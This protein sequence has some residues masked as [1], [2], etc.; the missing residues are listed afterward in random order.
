MIPGAGLFLPQTSHRSKVQ[1]LSQA[2]N[3]R[4]SSIQHL[5]DEQRMSQDAPSQESMKQKSDSSEDNTSTSD[6][7][8]TVFDY[9]DFVFASSKRPAEAELFASLIWHTRQD[10]TEASRLYLSPIVSSFLEAWPDRKSWI[11]KTVLDI[12]TAVLDIG[13]HIESVRGTRDDDEILRRRHKFRYTLSHQ[14]HLAQKQRTLANT[15]QVLLA[16]IQVMQTVEQC[17]GLGHGSRDPIFEA[18][19]R[20]WLRSDSELIRAPYSRRSSARNLSA[21]SVTTSEVADNHKS[22]SSFTK[23]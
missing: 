14:K 13:M 12:R 3:G 9:A 10:L 15:H 2:M 16:A 5:R 17:V 19:V 4:R 11:D 1:T 7:T 20:P 21:L 18:P 6:L 22:G 8:S 23:D